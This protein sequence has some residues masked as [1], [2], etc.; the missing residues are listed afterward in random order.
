M[1]PTIVPH[2]GLTRAAQG[3]GGRELVALHA[4]VAAWLVVPLMLLARADEVIE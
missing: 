2:I 3:V 4:S 1:A